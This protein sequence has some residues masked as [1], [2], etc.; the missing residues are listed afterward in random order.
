MPARHGRNLLKY[1]S[2][3]FSGLAAQVRQLRLFFRIVLPD[4]F[5][6]SA[7]ERV[8]LP[9]QSELFQANRVEAAD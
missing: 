5:T 8:E 9:L 1:Y 6:D 7:T 2:E 4:R 3:L